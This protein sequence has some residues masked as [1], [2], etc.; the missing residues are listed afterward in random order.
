GACLSNGFC[1]LEPPYFVTH[2]EPLEVS[3]GDYTTLQCHVAGT[4]EITVSWYKGDT[5]LRSTP[6]YKVFFKDNVA[7]LIFNKVVSNDSGEYTCKAE[8]SVGTASTK[9]LLTVQERKRPP[10]FARK[11][12]DIEHPV[13]LPLKFMCRLNGSEPITVTW[14]KDGV[15]LSDDHNVH[16]SFVD[17]V[18]VLQLVRT[19]M[20]HTGQYSCTATNAVGTATSSARLT[21]QAPVFDTK[22]ESIDV[23]FGESA[24]FE[25]HVTGAQPIHITWS[26]DGRE[27]R[28]G[29]N[30]SITFVANTAHLRVLRVGKG[31]SGQYTCQA[32]NEAGKDFCSAQLSV[33]E[34]PKFIKKPEALRFVKQGDAVQLECKISGTPEIRTVWYKNDQALLASD[35]LHMSFVDSVAMLTILGA[36]TEDAGDYIC[37]AHNSA[38]TASCSTSVTVKEPPVFSKVPSPVDT[39][40]GSD[41]ILQCEIAGTPPFE[42]AWFKDRRQVRSS[43]KFKVTTKQSI[44]SLHIL[45]LESQDTGEYQC[46]AMN[47][48]GS[49]TCTCPVKFKE[50]PRFA[51]KLSDTAIFVGEPTALQA[52]VEGS[53]PIS[54]I[55][56][57]DKGEVIRESENVQMWFM[58]NIAT[59][60]IASAEGA[61]VGKY[62]CQIK[63]DAGMRECSAFLQVLG[64]YS[65]LHRYCILQLAQLPLPACFLFISCA[66]WFADRFPGDTLTPP[67][68]FQNRQLS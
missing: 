42:V 11:L 20:N 8:N 56:L 61:D 12:K 38:G 68:L 1:F 21:V 40:K 24:D 27:I 35:R 54:V 57:K 52:V 23:P 49:D 31:D 33:K 15:L 16:T 58:D 48:V 32:S 29:G 22:P 50:P 39:L 63:N 6:E 17:N 9:A 13:G 3:V 2:L 55:W 41:V 47:E 36:N 37:E 5:K 67:F 10:S 28:T 45:N 34:P 18:A 62:I 64:G 51:K 60:E 19:E 25:C 44:A 65:L 30:F 53:P 26:K 66:H 43:K 7:T 14:H 59:L 46:K 4:P